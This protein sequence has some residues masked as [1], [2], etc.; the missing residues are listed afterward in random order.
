MDG[1]FTVLI[2]GAGTTTAISVLKG[3]RK[4]ADPTLRVIMA[5][6]QSDCAGAHL[7]DAFTRLPLA[8]DPDFADR[9]VANT[10]RHAV[11]LVIPII[12]YEFPIW[13]TLA[14]QLLAEGTRV[15]I[16]DAETIAICDGKDRTARYFAERDIPGPQTWRA[17]DIDDPSAL[18]YPVFIKP[19]CG[20]GSLD[21]WAAEDD[22][23]YRH[24][25]RQVSEP[26]IQPRLHGPEVTIDTLSD[27]S[28]K[29]LG[30]SA[31]IR[32]QV[33]SG[34]A[35][36]S[37]TLASEALRQYAQRIVEGLPIVGP[38]NIQGF[39]TDHGP[40][41]TEVNARFG[42]G[43]I[44]SIEAGF[45]GP[46][47]LVAMA[48]G[49]PLPPLTA[50]PGV[51][52]YRYWQE[53]FAMARGGPL[54]LDLDGPLLDV[55]ARHHRVYADI[56]TGAGQEPLNAADY[57]AAK[58]AGKGHQELLDG[59]SPPGFFS[60][61]FEPQWLARIESP[62]FLA[63][64]RVWPAAREVLPRLQRE[65]EL[66]LVTVRS[67]PEQLARQLSDLG[68]TPW[69]SAVLCR[70]ARVNAAQ[71][72]IDVIRE[73]FDGTVPTGIIVGDT[74]ADLACGQALGLTRVGVL[75]GI[76]DR[77]RLEAAGG[78]YLIAS[79]ADLPALLVELGKEGHD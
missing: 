18:P 54:F 68:L 41:F 72:K 20:R 66:F 46:A 33:K 16:S 60:D 34:Q 71:A 11:D 43:T 37:V 67:Q 13:A 8:S 23:A 15:V 39:L 42:A 78:D 26:I 62:E 6:A 65:H 38:A 49:T 51:W 31:R 45:N 19:R 3:L 53:V 10:R 61:V 58:R 17:E 77:R 9:A 73:H 22:T 5:D 40:R 59:C 48:R 2:T 50:R 1:R 64:D 27:F 24:H 25:V 70:P 63:L 29:F 57:W 14:E 75:N 56:L 52:M 28:G 69:F 55:S 76:R 30:A 4:L 36:R 35:F 7:G 12:D 21:A 44:L 32:V 47:A 74:E 79:I